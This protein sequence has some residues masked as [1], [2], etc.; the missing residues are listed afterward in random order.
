MPIRRK[1]LT[2]LRRIKMKTLEDVERMNKP[3]VVATVIRSAGSVPGKTGASMVVFA[4]GKIEGTVGGGE[5]EHKVIKKAVSLIQKGKSK[6]VKFNLTGKRIK[7][8]VSTK[9]ICGGEVEIFFNVYRPP[10][11]LIVCGAGHIGVCLVKLAKFL[12]WNCEVIDDRKNFVKNLSLKDIKIVVSPYKKAFEKAAVDK[13]SAIVIVT[14]N[15]SGD[16]ACL[17]GA[18]KTKAFYIGMIGSRIKIAAN[19]RK[20][21]KR[22]IV[23]D[24]RV[25]SPI[26][27]DLGGDSPAEIALC[28]VSEIMKI[29]HRKKAGHLRI[30]RRAE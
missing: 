3:F 22:G 5:I 11:K 8:S 2:G 28:I 29:R 10:V 4:T 1:I 14:H 16:A 26:G 19:F 23:I 15:H 25:F 18:L 7:K 9:M 20:F 17:E 30:D 6:V 13:N 24:K 12:E 27:L 21:R